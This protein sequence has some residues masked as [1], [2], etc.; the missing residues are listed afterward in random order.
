MGNVVSHLNES[1]FWQKEKK[2]VVYRLAGTTSLLANNLI[3]FANKSSDEQLLAIVA[4]KNAVLVGE[5]NRVK[6]ESGEIV[7]LLE[8]NDYR[9]VIVTNE[10]IHLYQLVRPLETA[11]LSHICSWQA[12]GNNIV[13]A[14][15][16]E[17]GNKVTIA[18]DNNDIVTFIANT[19]SLTLTTRVK[20]QHKSQVVSLA[21][22][23][24]E[25][26]SIDEHGLLQCWIFP[27]AEPCPAYTLQIKHF[28]TCMVVYKSYIISEI[29]AHAGQVS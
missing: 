11:S 25:L 19:F 4:T 7:A 8:L 22:S 14:A 27:A 26:V 6:I 21:A 28:V 1:L 9:I 12:E 29:Y 24:N 16:T 23:E 13:A 20:G 17:N 18:L 3:T 5:R 10:K 15:S 2:M